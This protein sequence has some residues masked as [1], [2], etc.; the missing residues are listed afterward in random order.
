[1]INAI[2]NF[3]KYPKFV[4]DFEGT[5][6]SSRDFWEIFKYDISWQFD[7]RKQSCCHKKDW[8][9]RAKSV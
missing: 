1:M 9:D 8:C 2:T 5:W 3:I 4:T 6:F 7:E